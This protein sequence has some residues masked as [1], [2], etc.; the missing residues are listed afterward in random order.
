MRSCRPLARFVLGASLVWL[1]GC[2]RNVDDLK[3]AHVE[4]GDR[5]LAEKN[6]D[7]AVIEYR[8]A[9]QQDPRFGEAYRKLAGAYSLRGDAVDALRAAVTAAD[10]LPAS[11]D[12]QVEAGELLLLGGS[13]DEAK[14][15]A[16]KALA[17]DPN[18][19]R[20]R[21]LLGNAMA[22]LRDIDSAMKEFEEALRLDPQQSGIYSGMAV[23]KANEGD[24]QAAERIFQQAIAVDEKSTT[25]RLA[26]AQFYWSSERLA[27]AEQV[28]RAAL[29]AAPNDSR[30]HVS[31]AVF[32]QATRR[33]VEAEPHLQAAMKSDSNPR[34]AIL[35]A[36]YY[37]ARNRLSDASPLLRPL[38]ADR[39]FGPLAN[40]RLAGIAQIQGNANEALEIIDATITAD[41][42]N[43]MALAAKSNVLREGLKIDAALE[44]AMT[45]VSA[46]RN[47]VDAH[48]AH[49]RA[50]MAKGHFDKAEKAFQ[51][52]LR[53][54]PR[55]TAARVQLAHLRLRDNVGEAVILATEATQLDPQ[56]LDA[57]LALART[58]MEKREYGQAEA[59]LRRLEQA[60]ATVPAV[61]A[62]MGTLLMRRGDRGAARATWLR[63]LELDP[64]H[65]EAL[66]GV[67]T[68][69]FGAR[70]H[71]EA[72][73]RLDAAVR[74]APTNVGVLTLA[75]KAYATLQRSDPA[76]SLL[77]KAIEADPA[78]LEAYST[79]G[80]LY[81]QQ[82]RLQLARAQF[83][84][85]AETQDRPVAALTLVG[86][87]DMLENRPEQARESFE[88]VLKIDSRAGVAANNLAWIYA[89]HGGSLDM[90]LQLAQVARTAMPDEAE[91]NDTLG[92]IYFRKGMI[93]PA[94][95][96]LRR[97]LELDPANATI[98]YHLALAHEKGGD[99]REA[100]RL[101]THYLTLDST[102]PRSA[103]VKQ[104]LAGAM[105]S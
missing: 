97:G 69:D 12:A 13:F 91:V 68:V 101:L 30:A 61:H 14:T 44:A 50:L 19:V 92:W 89:E 71:D 90:A 25:A 22:G 94:I 102:S 99:T 84:K 54:N 2:S 1:A 36:D 72:I 20:A 26:L 3:R 83:N 42:K 51:E 59:I 103:E 77:L 58:L 17:T 60:A 66:A 46:N 16:R 96:A 52:V 29:V 35:L 75:A 27:E 65:F 18:H 15:R 49:G 11:A 105:G 33:P 85:V 64:V 82:E 70:R 67:T 34:L 95:E 62:Q 86:I 28:L 88:R 87:I 45:A 32:L 6:H 78:A 40:M 76:E 41:P 81:M 24:M 37:I 73:A 74:R 47:S 79:L 98:A 9:V 55:A 39:R 21:V 56:S 8:N 93:E 5:Y 48:F 31:L 38:A 100:R 63:A 53:L 104:R 57:Q 23:L 7:A 10:L 4:R 43:A 80:A